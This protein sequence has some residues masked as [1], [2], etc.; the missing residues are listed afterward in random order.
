MNLIF[1][2]MLSSLTRKGLSLGLVNLELLYKFF[3]ICQAYNIPM[4]ILGNCAKSN[5]IASLKPMG[6]KGAVILTHLNN[7]L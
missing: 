6:S 1:S 2:L 5:R 3:Q 4:K 7:I